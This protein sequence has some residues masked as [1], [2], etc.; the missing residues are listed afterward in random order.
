MDET[1]SKAAGERL[2]IDI[3][4]VKTKMAMKKFWVLIED[5]AMCMKWSYF[6]NQK[7]NQV[8]PIVNL[9]KE[10]NGMKN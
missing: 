8:K 6:V 3:S 2:C 10:I 7:S 1:K 5:Q 9:I 4:S